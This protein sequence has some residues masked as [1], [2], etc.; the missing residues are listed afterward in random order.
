RGAEELEFSVPWEKRQ[1][2]TVATARLMWDKEYLYFCADMEDA[3]LYAVVDKANGKTWED[4]VFQLYFKPNHAKKYPLGYYEF[5]VTAANTPLQVLY[6]SRGGGGKKRFLGQVV[7]AIES[8]VTL[9]GTLNDWTD[10]DKGWTVEGRIPWA[11]FQLTGG[12]PQPGDR[13]KFALSRW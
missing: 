9:K 11:A 1:A 4:D 5:N 6:A 10:K 2:R 12:R 7:I 13:W 3:D 8:T